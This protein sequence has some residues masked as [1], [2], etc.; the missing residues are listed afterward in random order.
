LFFKWHIGHLRDLSAFECAVG[1]REMGVADRQ[2]FWV[3]KR[4]VSHF[5]VEKKVLLSG[6]MPDGFATVVFNYKDAQEAETALELKDEKIAGLKVL[7][8]K[9]RLA[10][11]I[12]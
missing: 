4:R 12:V 9:K 8:H 10:Y 1:E 3:I 5:D 2:I 11:R 7:R 6:E